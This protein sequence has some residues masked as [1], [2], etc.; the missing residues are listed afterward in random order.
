MEVSAVISRWS[1]PIILC[2]DDT[3]NS[4]CVVFVLFVFGCSSVWSSSE[5]GSCAIRMLCGSALR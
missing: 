1:A 2:D 3:M 4:L 5:G